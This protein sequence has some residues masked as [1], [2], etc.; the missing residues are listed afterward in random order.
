MEESETLVYL[1]HLV[2]SK[3]KWSNTF[4]DFFLIS[5]LGERGEPGQAGYDGMYDFKFRFNYFA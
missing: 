2:G 1:E 3:Y 5:L 4:S